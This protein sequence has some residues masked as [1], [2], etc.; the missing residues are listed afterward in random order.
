MNSY[1]GLS[2]S[3]GCYV[4]AKNIK[5]RYHGSMWSLISASFIYANNSLYR[6]SAFYVY[7][8]LIHTKNLLARVIY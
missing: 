6:E 3:C 4:R 1:G 2:Y 8:A 5:I 7:T